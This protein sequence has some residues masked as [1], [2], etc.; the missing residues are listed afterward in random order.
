MEEDE[1]FAD[2]IAIVIMEHHATASL[3]QRR[4]C[5]AYK[6]AEKLLDMLQSKGIIGP[7]QGSKPREIL[8]GWEYLDRLL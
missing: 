4:L 6:R 1:L 8:V 5:V 2:A 3:L 7:A